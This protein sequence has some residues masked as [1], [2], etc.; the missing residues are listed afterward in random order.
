M[1]QEKTFTTFIENSSFILGDK[2]RGFL[3]PHNKDADAIYKDALRV[4]GR[5]PYATRS[6]KTSSAKGP[7]NTAELA[8]L[9]TS[10]F[11]FLL[12]IFLPLGLLANALSFNKDQ[13]ISIGGCLLLIVGTF[14]FWQY[15][16]FYKAKFNIRTK[17]YKDASDVDIREK[18]NDHME[19]IKS[20]IDNIEVK[21]DIGKQSNLYDQ[22]TKQMSAVLTL[23]L[24]LSRKDEFTPEEKPEESK[25]DTSTDSVESEESS[26][27]DS[28]K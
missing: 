1:I 15:C 12:V 11:F 16:R 3:T 24:S 6:S 22:L 19:D 26:A 13:G 10:I 14:S 18:I 20:S 28:E 4:I 21:S 9:A 27:D 2:P 7:M 25:D 23:A 5:K 17:P 8:D